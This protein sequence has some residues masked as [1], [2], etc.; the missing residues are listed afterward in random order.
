MEASSA[1]L[2]TIPMSILFSTMVTEAIGKAIGSTSQRDDLGTFT[3]ALMPGDHVL[4]SPALL[5]ERLV[6]R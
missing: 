4:R 3:G 2:L 5:G 1:S 6:V